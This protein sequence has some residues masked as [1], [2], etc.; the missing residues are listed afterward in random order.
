MYNEFNFNNGFTK[1]YKIFDKRDTCVWSYLCGPSS[2][3]PSGNGQSGGGGGIPSTGAVALSEI[4]STLGGSNPIS[5]S[6]Y[7]SA[8]TQL[9]ASGTISVS[10]FQGIANFPLD[11]LSMYIDPGNTS[12]YSGS[13]TT[14]NDLSDTQTSSLTLNN[15]TY[16]SSNGGIF[17]F[18]GTSSFIQ[19]PTSPVNMNRVVKHYTL[20]FFMKCPTGTNF[21][22]FHGT[23]PTGTAVPAMR[24]QLLSTRWFKLTTTDGSGSSYG[25]ATGT[26][27][28]IPAYPRLTGNTWT[29]ICL[30]VDSSASCGYSY[31]RT[32]QNGS[33]T[34]NDYMSTPQSNPPSTLDYEIGRNYSGGSA[35]E[36]FDGDIGVMLY[37]SN[38]QT[39]AEVSDVYDAFKSRYG[40][41]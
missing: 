22:L 14:V 8:D 9:P 16:N 38:P 24:W 5:L 21:T 3:G 19:L 28:Y 1:S 25:T 41:T 12:C 40:L 15:V 37:Y 29:H 32:F 18:N 11:H 17:Q 31:L 6:E 7:Y 35:S 23:N 33:R 20:H 10:D 2:G 26:A 13:G 4:Q 30:M 34:D 36:Y 39:D 27:S